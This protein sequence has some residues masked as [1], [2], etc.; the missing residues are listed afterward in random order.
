MRSV[1]AEAMNTE[2]RAAILLSV[3]RALWGQVTP[4]IRAVICRP[5]GDKAFGIEFYIDGPVADSVKE[6][7]SC[8][9]TEVLADFLADFDIAHSVI[10]LDA[11]QPIPTDGSLVVYVRKE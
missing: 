11:P 5:Q 7:A 10:R 4:E 2:A 9:E 1:D 3:M 6:S 8:V